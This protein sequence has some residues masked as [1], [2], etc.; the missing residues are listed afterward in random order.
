MAKSKTKQAGNVVVWIIIGLLTIGL[1]G[2]GIGG[3]GGHIR[4]IGSVGDTD[5]PVDRYAQALRQELRSLQ[6]QTGQ[7]FTL[8]QLQSFGLDRAV[9]QQVV[10]T[11]ALDNEAGRVGLSVGD[12]AVRREVLRTP[13]FQGLDGTFSRESYEFA[14]RQEG[15]SVNEF[16]A[17]VRADTARSL[18]QGAI[19]AGASTPLTFTDTLFGYARETR[20]FT[21]VPFTSDDLATPLPE[22]TDEVL[23]KYYDEH[24]DQFTLPERRSI[25]YAW[26]TP[27]MVVDD[28]DVDEAGLRALYDERIDEY[29]QPERRLVERLVFGTTQEATEAKAKIDSGETGFDDLVAARGLD[30]TDVDLGD[31]SISDLGTAGAAVFALTEP[32]VTGPLDTGL[33]PALFRVNGILAAHETTF[34]EASDDL[35][36]EFADGAA[37]RLIQDQIEPADDLLA[38]GVTL[39][40]LAADTSMEFGDVLLDDAS[41]AP[42]AAYEAF[43][44]AANAA[45]VGDFPEIADLEDGG[46]FALRLNEIVPPTL[47]PFEDVKVAVIGNWEQAETAQALQ[48]QAEA[49]QAAVENG[50]ELA[51]AGIEPIAEAG[52]MRDAFIQAAPPTLVSTAFAMEPGEVK[53]LSDDNGAVL[54]RLDAVAVPEQDTDEAKTIRERFAA[55]TAQSYGQDMLSAF[56]MAIE[57]HTG[58]SL[59][60]TAI[61]AVHA[62]FP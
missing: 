43:R 31:V 11:A 7:S 1:A 5:I 60:Q 33:G 27:T 62:Q 21:Y 51:S 13:A 16:E 44:E 20:D 42:I 55:Q 52:L 40:E 12:D 50:A 18:L 17:T 19:V 35:R 29:K 9:L 34:E 10:A 45:E 53:V 6:A 30:L 36:T 14:L 26:M 28:V 59:D 8:N 32:G 46:I 61:N 2:F 38:G 56:T 58:I 15:Q 47:Q 49:L 57:S 54:L 39:E 48:K 4:T 24:P 41:D 3:F 25:S 37:R 22:P 23:K